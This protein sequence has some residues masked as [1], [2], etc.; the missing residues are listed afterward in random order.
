MYVQL[1]D[2]MA[3][4][5]HV[6]A[7]RRT[8][9]MLRCGQVEDTVICIFESLDAI[10]SWMVPEHH[11]VQQDHCACVRF[12]LPWF[13]APARHVTDVLGDDAPKKGVV[14]HVVVLPRVPV[15]TGR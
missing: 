8:R 14:P 4:C 7:A 2:Q 9:V 6:E 3:I 13:C 1:W 12:A 10:V 15:P 11:G 5:K